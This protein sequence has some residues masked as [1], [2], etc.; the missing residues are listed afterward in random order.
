MRRVELTKEE[1]EIVKRYKKASEEMREAEKEVKELKTVLA[2]DESV[3]LVYNGQVIGRILVVDV[4]RVDVNS[5]PKEIKEAYMKIMRDK[6]LIIT[7]I[8]IEVDS[9]SR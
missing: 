4:R 1:F 3:E 2:G 6:R 5:I 8:P 9:N 7:G